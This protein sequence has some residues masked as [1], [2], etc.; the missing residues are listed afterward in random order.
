MADLSLWLS[1]VAR[2]LNLGLYIGHAEVTWTNSGV[3]RG[4]IKVDLT[5][6][7]EVWPNG[8]LDLAPFVP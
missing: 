2:M 7:S 3:R 5:L 1:S 6:T 4:Y 8:M